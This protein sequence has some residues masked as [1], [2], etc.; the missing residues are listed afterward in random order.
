M[1]KLIEAAGGL[2]VITTMNKTYIG[3]LDEAKSMIRFALRYEDKGLRHW[4]TDYNLGEL[5]TVHF[6]PNAGFTYRQL[7]SAESA[8]IEICLIL[9]EEAKN[10]VI[11]HA[12]NELFYEL[13]KLRGRS[14]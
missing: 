1:E 13:Y 6:N 2:R 9:M 8:E 10:L 3:V 5:D 4:I 12:E 14:R 7:D 11:A